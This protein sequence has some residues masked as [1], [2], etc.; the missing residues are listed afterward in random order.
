[1]AAT[2][3]VWAGF[4]LSIRGIG[5]SGLTTMDVA[6]IRFTT[7]VILLSP[8]IPRTLRSLSRERPAVV[9]ALCVGAGLPYFAVSALAVR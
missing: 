5:A 1:M 7:P 3:V 6:L 9:A 4:A 8:W 2:V